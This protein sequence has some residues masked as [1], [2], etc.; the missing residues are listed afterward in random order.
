MNKTCNCQTKW[1]LL[2]LLFIGNIAIVCATGQEPDIIYI[3]NKS[4]YLL[5]RPI[6]HDARLNEAIWQYLPARLSVSTGNWYGYTAVWELKNNKLCLKSIC[7]ENDDAT[8][9]DRL[10]K[11]KF[12]NPDAFGD[13]FEPYR[14]GE[15]IVASWYTDSVS[16]GY[17][18]P[19][20]YRHT[21]FN[22]YYPDETVLYFD[23]GRLINQ[24]SYS[25]SKRDGLP[26]ASQLS[27]GNRSKDENVLSQIQQLFPI[28]K[29]QKLTDHRI[30]FTLENIELTAD[31]RYKNSEIDFRIFRKD[32]REKVKI[33]SSMNKKLVKA[34]HETLASIYPWETYSIRGK[35][36]PYFPGMT[37][38]LIPVEQ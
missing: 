4:Y 32:N 30:L 5:D 36:I 13:L 1:L 33:S 2:C 15:D 34:M 3:Q 7:I 25:N 6:A 37:A 35:H 14:E 22:V 24:V 11:K 23:A 12:Y 27:T 31:G 18:E 26:L 28:E 29:F 9:A 17:G 10:S 20:L 19:V 38:P 21:G 8:G 16:T